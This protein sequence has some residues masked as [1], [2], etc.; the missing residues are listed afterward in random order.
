MGGAISA[1]N[2]IIVLDGTPSNIFMNNSGR[3]GGAVHCEG[4]LLHNHHERQ[5]NNTFVNNVAL[6]A[7][8]EEGVSG[9][10]LYLGGGKVLFMSGSVYFSKNRAL[11]SGGAIF[12]I[13]SKVYPV[14][15]EPQLS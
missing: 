7:K 11:Y 4:L 12:V 9:G 5:R 8:F 13:N 14:Q 15:L 1:R 3:Q 2:G 6:S 10:A